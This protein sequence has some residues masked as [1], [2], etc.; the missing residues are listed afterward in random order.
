MGLTHVLDFTAYDHIL[1]LIVLAVVFSLYQWK[2]VLWSV[3]FP[4]ENLQAV[5]E[6]ML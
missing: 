1:F 3:Y 4:E 2:K 5:T 6:N